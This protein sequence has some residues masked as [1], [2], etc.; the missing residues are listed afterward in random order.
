[1]RN[2]KLTI[3]YD[4]TNYLGWQRQKTSPTIQEVIENS[5]EKITGEK[6]IIYGSGR[7]DTGVHA[8]GQVANFKTGSALNPE[9]FQKGLNSIL[10]GDIVITKAVRLIKETV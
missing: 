2:I 4:G 7:T 9:I 1:M 3:E 8:F 10:P 6:V 5:L